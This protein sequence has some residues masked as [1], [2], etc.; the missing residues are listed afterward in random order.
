MGI[1]YSCLLHINSLKFKSPK[2]SGNLTTV[3]TDL[4]G[5]LDL[6]WHKTIYVPFLSTEWQHLYISVQK[7]TFVC[8]CVF[9][10]TLTLFIRLTFILDITAISVYKFTHAY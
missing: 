1:S 6:N 3:F 9:W 4:V 5:K 10:K 8:V 2:I 7:R